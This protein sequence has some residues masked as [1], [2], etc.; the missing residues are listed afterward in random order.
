MTVKKDFN[1]LAALTLLLPAVTSE[2]AG[3]WL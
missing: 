1:G 2:S 3:L